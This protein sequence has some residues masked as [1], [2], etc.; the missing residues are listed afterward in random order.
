MDML[1]KLLSENA[2]LSLEQL[3]SLTGE[4]EKV[5][6]EKMDAL[7]KDHI[8]AGYR[9]VVNWE[10]AGSELVSSIIEVRISPKRDFGFDE[11]AS[12]ISS[13]PEVENVY[14]MSGGYDLAITV[15]G[16]SFRD[17][18]MFVA[19]RL[20]PMES[21]LSTATHFILRK[22]KENGLILVDEPGDERGLASL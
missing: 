6:A 19:K 22:Y 10:K 4:S 3:A 1:L 9:A 17:I 18:A 5:V 15:H 14:L 21:V 2:R 11:F 7:E 8:I 13:F 20:S 16:A 12:T